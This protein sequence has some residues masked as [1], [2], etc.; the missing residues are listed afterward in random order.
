MDIDKVPKSVGKTLE[1]KGWVWRKRESKDIIF[2]VIRDSSDVVQCTITD[3]HKD[4]KKAKKLT[5][6]SSVIIKGRVAK[7][8]RAPTGYEIKISKLE[9]VHI[10]ERFPITKDKSTEFLLDTRHLWLRSRYLTAAMKV[11]H[12]V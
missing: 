6:E 8:K 11:R 12:T 3:R 4:F 5:I 2:L 7:D 10:A 9:P 1:I